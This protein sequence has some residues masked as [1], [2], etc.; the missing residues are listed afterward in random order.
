MT[1]TSAVG[2]QYPR[3]FSVSHSGWS[4]GV[5][6]ATPRLCFSLTSCPSLSHSRVSLG[7]SPGLGI[8]ASVLNLYEISKHVVRH[9]RERREQQEESYEMPERQEGS[10]QESPYQMPQPNTRQQQEEFYDMPQLPMRTRTPTAP[11]VD[12]PPGAVV[13]RSDLPPGVQ[14]RVPPRG[15]V[16]SA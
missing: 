5:Q 9:V 6:N 3:P 15:I 7:L 14:A 2:A 16:I 8:F 4:T 1:R 10:Y 13:G 12:V 11:D